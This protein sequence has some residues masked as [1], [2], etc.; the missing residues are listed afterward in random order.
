MSNMNDMVKHP[1]HYQ[2]SNGIEVRQVLEGFAPTP[3]HVEGF[4]W[5]NSVK[6]ILRW[7]KKGGLEDLKKAREN[8]D[9]LIKAV[10]VYHD[11]LTKFGEVHHEDHT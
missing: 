7:H 3:E 1:K 6:Y 5:G 2:G 10:E 9:Y 8:L 11:L 4:Y